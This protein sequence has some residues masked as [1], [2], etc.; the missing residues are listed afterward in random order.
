[1][2][3]TNAP[4]ADASAFAKFTAMDLKSRNGSLHRS[5]RPVDDLEIARVRRPPGRQLVFPHPDLPVFLK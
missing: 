4:E 2:K 3:A 1:M 5:L